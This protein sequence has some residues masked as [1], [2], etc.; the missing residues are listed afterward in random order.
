MAVNKSNSRAVALVASDKE[1]A[2]LRNEFPIESSYQRILLP[3]LGLI[4]QDV[5]EGRGKSL[6]VIAEAGIFYIDRQEDEE[7]AET[8]KKDWNR[9]ELGTSVE[10]IILY[11]RKQLRFYDGEKYT[12]SPIY[13]SNDEVV[14]LFK[15][16]AEVARGIPKE[17]QARPEFQGT[18]AKGKPTS[19]LEENRILYVL[20]KGEIYQLNIR[21]TS[22]FAFFKYSREVTPNTVLTEFDS[23]PKE[24]GATK[25]NQMTFKKV[26]VITSKEAKEVMERIQSLKEGILAEKAFYAGRDPNAKRDDETQE[27]YEGRLARAK[28]FD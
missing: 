28:D 13:D 4:S 8:G 20:Y 11:Q 19:K 17:L 5:T 12:S 1:L 15:D 27:E 21:G 9:E 25:W 10:A 24:N 23:E 16:K 3:R 22:M 18:T 6:K 26:R 14:P 7:N 2:A